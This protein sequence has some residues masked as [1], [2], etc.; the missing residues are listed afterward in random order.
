MDEFHYGTSHTNRPTGAQDF[1]DKILPNHLPPA[2]KPPD[3]PATM[4]EFINT[5][6]T[7][8][9]PLAL[10]SVTDPTEHTITANAA[11][12]LIDSDMDD[13]SDNPNAA[14]LDTTDPDMPDLIGRS[15]HPPPAV[16]TVT[17]NPNAAHITGVTRP[18]TDFTLPDPTPSHTPSVETASIQFNPG[19][20]TSASHTD[21]RHAI[22]STSCNPPTHPV[23]AEPRLLA[24]HSPPASPITSNIS[25]G[26]TELFTAADQEE[27]IH[28]HASF[29]M[30]ATP[31]VLHIPLNRLP[32]LGLI[33]S[34]A[35]GTSQVFVK[36]CQEGT[37]VSK[38]NKRRSLIR[39]SVVRSVNNK[40]V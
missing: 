24:H 1:L 22:P 21:D 35:P 7:S 12:L 10:D 11:Q 14:P 19:N 34:E 6:L 25:A 33:L 31:T 17:D 20:G 40:P 30:Y 28:M 32:T 39:N 38:M 27:I 16:L 4:P 26:V 36:N 8:T 18:D 2:G 9:P 15:Y 23:I 5:S 37:A 29:D 3:S 13:S